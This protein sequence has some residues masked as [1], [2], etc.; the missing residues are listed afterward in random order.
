VDERGYVAQALFDRLIER[1]IEFCVL[2]DAR[3]YPESIPSDIDMAVSAR[4]FKLMPRAIA[5]FCHDFGLRLVQMVRYERTACHFVLTWR[6]GSGGLRFLVPD[7]CSDYCHSGRRLLSAD[8][9][10]SRRQVAVSA[11]GMSRGFPVPAPDVQ[12]VYYLTKKVDKLD[13]CLEHGDYL[14]QQW[15]ADL[16]RAFRRMVRFW[17]ESVDNELIARAATDNEW[18]G[19]RAALPQLRRSL[20]RSVSLS[21]AEALLQAGVLLGRVLRP[22]GMTVACMGPDGSGK[23]SVIERVNAE[24][25]LAFRCTKVF[26]LRP[27][28]LAS[29]PDAAAAAVEGA[30]VAPLRGPVASLAKLAGMV[31]DYLVGHAL[32]VWPMVTRSGLV[33]FDRYFHDLLIDPKRYRYGGSMRIARAAA[34]LVPEPDIW[35]VLEASAAVLKARKQ[36]LSPEELARQRRRNLVFAAQIRD[37]A[38]IDAGRSLTA[39]TTD[40][41]EAI[42]VWLQNRVEQ[43]HLPAF[44]EN[45][46]GA[47]ALLFVCRHKVPLFGKLVRLLFNSDIDCRIRSSIL[48]PHPYGIVIHSK[49][50]VGSGVTVMQQVTIGNKEPGANVAPVIEDGVY[51]G[52]GARIL[53]A[54]RVGRGAVIGANAVVTRDVPSYCTVVGANRIL[55]NYARDGNDEDANLDWEQKVDARRPLSSPQES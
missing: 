22:A 21:P 27:G 15:H 20:M 13:L 34:H 53:G 49:A 54:I 4:E 35:I 50:R 18:D 46:L 39:V 28:L 47:R 52:A 5:Q 33:A 16:D 7:V 51:V 44:P 48:M 10:I 40:V 42:L 2:G 26:Q 11:R 8:E 41:A 24:L 32:R 19:V 45:P 23:S 6:D 31:A 30:P 14:S 36:D 9:L 55:H 17:P 43:R 25:A 3:R 29:G 1:D 38:V 12:F 37:A